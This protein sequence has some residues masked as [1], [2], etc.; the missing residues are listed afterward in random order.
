MHE[1]ALD[2]E[3]AHH[4]PAGRAQILRHGGRDVIGKVGLVR[5]DIHDGRRPCRHGFKKG[6]AFGIDDGVVGIDGSAHEFL[7]DVRRGRFL[8]EEPF[9]FRGGL[10]AEGV[11]GAGADV[12]LHD[13]RVAVFAREG[14]AF[15]E[16]GNMRESRRGDMRF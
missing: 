16:G 2:I 10:D 1:A 7:H 6:L 5:D 11:L 12:R 9:Q 4:G 15:L 3:G 14:L 13:D 8:P